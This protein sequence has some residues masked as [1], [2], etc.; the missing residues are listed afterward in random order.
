MIRAPESLRLHEPGQFN[1]TPMIDVVFLLIIFFM[2]ICQFI[3]S[4]NYKLLVPD[5]CQGAIASEKLDENAVTLSVFP[6]ES[7]PSG[8]MFAVRS[9][10]FD[11]DSPVYDGH[12]DK[13][14]AD[15]GAEIEK[16]LHDRSDPIVYLRA[17]RALTYAQVQ[18]A[19]AA[20]ARAKVTRLQLAAFKHSHNDTDVISDN[21]VSNP[22]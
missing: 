12:R 15:M 18:D 7:D 8:E 22:R 17:D 21:P 3:A 13:L 14:V 9:R 10:T 19:L 11:P 20:L 2:L 4:E 16:Q 1:M 6:D 5:R